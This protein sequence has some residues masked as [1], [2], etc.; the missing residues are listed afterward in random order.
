MHEMAVGEH[1]AAVSVT[2]VAWRHDPACGRLTVVI[3]PVQVPAGAVWWPGLQAGC[4]AR[5]QA[6]AITLQCP[7][8]AQARSRDRSAQSSIQP[9]LC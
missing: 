8:D 5:A 2:Q 4:Q 6:L 1:R 7:D 3:D 9:R